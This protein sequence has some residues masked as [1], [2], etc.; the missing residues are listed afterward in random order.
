[1]H[2]LER[3][4]R[5]A[6]S[7][8]PRRIPKCFICDH[9]LL[10]EDELE[11]GCLNCG[12]FISAKS[13]IKLWQKFWDLERCKKSG[14]PVGLVTHF[15]QPRCFRMHCKCGTELSVYTKR[16]KELN[17]YKGHAYCSLCRAD[18]SAEA[19]TCTEVIDALESQMLHANSNSLPLPNVIGDRIRMLRLSKKLS[20]TQLAD[21]SD[22][23]LTSI[24]RYESGVRDVKIN[25]L[26][27]IAVALGVDV[28]SFF[29]LFLVVYAVI[30]Y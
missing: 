9:S 11:I 17:I 24:R 19:D 27:K 8:R 4:I 16:D 29:A 26:K 14:M 13:N 3:K 15:D 28:S 1:M 30:F 22:L 12:F 18:F 10:F 25:Q 23:S 5:L 21:A 7:N 6:Q 20:Q 2:L